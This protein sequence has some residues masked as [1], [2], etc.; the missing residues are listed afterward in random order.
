MLQQ[1][2]ITALPDSLAGAPVERYAVREAPTLS[3]LVDRSLLWHPQ[4]SDTGTH[5]FRFAAVQ[6]DTTRALLLLVALQ[7]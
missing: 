1:P 3:W 7:P 6:A 5:A 2:F 4:P